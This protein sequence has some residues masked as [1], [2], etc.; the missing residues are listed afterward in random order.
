[1]HGLVWEWVSDFSASML[2][3]A[4][5][6]LCGAGAA[7]AFDPTDYPAFLRAAFRSAVQARTT[8]SNLG[9]RCAAGPAG[10]S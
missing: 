10:A 3:G 2:V 7:S 8:T 9:F 5:A 4:D 6:R 1:M